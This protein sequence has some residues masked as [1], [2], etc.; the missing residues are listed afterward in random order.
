M[1]DFDLFDFL[2]DGSS[3]A[4]GS[5]LGLLSWLCVLVAF[6]SRWI[7][8]LLNVGYPWLVTGPIVG[9]PL[10][11]VAG[12]LLGFWGRQSPKGGDMARWAMMINLIVLA[13]SLLAMVTFFWILPAEYRR[14]L[15]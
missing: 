10:V 5:A 12:A 1:A 4:G 15:F 3:K 7:L 14:R 13:L 9:I 8:Q 11:S 6:F 2:D